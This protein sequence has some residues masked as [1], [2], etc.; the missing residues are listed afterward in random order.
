MTTDQDKVAAAAILVELS[1]CTRNGNDDASNATD[2][3]DFNG[4]SEDE[5]DNEDS[6]DDKI[7]VVNSSDD[8]GGD[9]SDDMYSNDDSKDEC[10]DEESRLN[11]T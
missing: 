2:N 10:D 3:I 9:E 11:K 8:S 6:G 7:D 1:R 4:G 5:N